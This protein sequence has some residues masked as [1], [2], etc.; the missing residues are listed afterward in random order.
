MTPSINDTYWPVLSQHLTKPGATLDDCTMVCDICQD[1]MKPQESLVH[2]VLY[3]P[4]EPP[5]TA[6][7]LPCGHIF[8]APCIKEWLNSCVER[9]TAPSCPS[10]RA[11]SLHP[12]CGHFVRPH[13]IPLTEEEYERL[14]GCTP[15]PPGK[16]VD[17][18]KLFRDSAREL[19]LG[20]K[21]T[22][23]QARREGMT[24]IP[25][26]LPQGGK[27]FPVCS[28]CFIQKHVQRCTREA[29]PWFAP[30]GLKGSQYVG[31]VAT[32]GRDFWNFIMEEENRY[33]RI[34]K[35]LP[36]NS[37]AKLYCARLQEWMAKTSSEMWMGRD[38]LGIKFTL[39][40]YE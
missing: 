38:L 21:A 32:L 6:V 4:K 23:K 16:K 10:C 1:K 27:L 20:W 3:Q 39:V 36:M 15:P 30:K 34:V 22:Q 37:E 26:T 28:F 2:E 11:C 18:L 8:G 24:R 9:Q 25:A 17:A 29:A 14:D 40:V 31:F 5:H 7:I 13:E 33:G 19:G 12:G 35:T